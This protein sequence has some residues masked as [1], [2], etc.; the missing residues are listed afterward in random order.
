MNKIEYL[1]TCAAE[2]GGEISQAA[3]KCA[4]FGLD[5]T[6]PKNENV[7]NIKLFIKEVNDLLGVVEL[8]Q[9]CEIPELLELGNRKDIEAKKEKVRHWMGYSRMMECLDPEEEEEIEGTETFE[10]LNVKTCMDCCLIYGP[11]YNQCPHCGS[12]NHG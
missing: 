11:E 1:L 4:R 3:A 10:D 6:H 5:D 9:E 12:A 2:E 8:L 7:P